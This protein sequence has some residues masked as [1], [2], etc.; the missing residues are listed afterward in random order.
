MSL[1]APLFLIG[2]AAIGLPILAHLIRRRPRGEITF[3]SLMFL[4]PSPPRLTR[5]SRIDHWPLLLI[6]S[7]VIV[8]LAAAFARPFLRSA[9]ESDTGLLGRRVVLLIDTS[10]SMRRSGLWTQALASAE[11]VVSDLLPADRLAIVAFDRRPRLLLGFDESNQIAPALRREAALEQLRALQPTWHATD[12]GR[13]LSFAAELTASYEPPDAVGVE[14]GELAETNPIGGSPAADPGH[15]ILISDLQSGSQIDSLQAFAW[16]DELR[17]DVRRVQA[18]ETT[19]A[20]ARILQPVAGDD[21]D[22]VRVRIF[23]SADAETAQFRLAWGS[24]EGIARESSSLPGQVPPGESRVV[25][26]LPADAQ[27]AS[28]V[29]SGD[30]HDFDNV[31]YFVQTEPRLRSIPY[32]GSESVL[33]GIDQGAEPAGDQVRSRGLLYYLSRLP[34]DDVDRQVTVRP[35]AIGDLDPA[36]EKGEV[37]MVVLARPIGSD[38][39]ARLVAYMRAGGHVLA[40]LADPL[41]GEEA[42][43]TLRALSGDGMLEVSEASIGDYAML[44]RI[45]FRHRLFASMS[46]PQF[47]DFSKIRFW[48]LRKVSTGEA[49]WTQPAAFDNGDPAFLER[50]IGDGMLTVMASGWHPDESQLA[51]S[52]KFLPLMFAL[53]GREVSPTQTSF[54][55]GGPI[56]AAPSPDARLMNPAGEWI[57]GDSTEWMDAIDRPGIYVWVDGEERQ[58]MA[59]NLDDSESRTDPLSEE[60]LERYGV[61]LG[62][63]S[64]TSQREERARQ[65]RDVELESQQKVWQW[66]LAA[67]L[68]L[69]GLEAWFGGWL[70]RRSRSESES[71]VSAAQ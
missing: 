16:P 27:D 53:L 14:A 57:D 49:G 24:A 43:Q 7:L 6:R 36:W 64:S 70:T 39:A 2:A 47:N 25:R 11:A 41:V 44:G 65:L 19:N 4:R 46:D 17:L 13:A 8:L 21:S 48:S 71:M 38:H 60:M 22:R 67:A 3:S 9:A 58:R 35:V 26:M 30:A 31:R 68:L 52:T 56:A 34:L 28:L 10:A 61:L 54:T 55:V 69:M 12:L 20:S 1:L 51:L 50:S 40:V 18:S 63:A 59:V 45:D 32:L 42:T 62:A 33:L 5:R 66:L 15:L 23:N 37:P 29:L